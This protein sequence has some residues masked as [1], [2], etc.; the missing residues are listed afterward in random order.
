VTYDFSL[1]GLGIVKP[2]NMGRRRAQG[3]LQRALAD[4]YRA[5]AGFQQALVSYDNAIADIN[6][7]VGDLVMED[8]MNVDLLNLTM[9]RTGPTS[10]S[11]WRSAS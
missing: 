4:M 5:R 6:S 9:A 10:A 1:D 8:N 7:K 3:E 11:T 2:E